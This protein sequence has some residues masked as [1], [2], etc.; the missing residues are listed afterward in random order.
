MPGVKEIIDSP[1]PVYL[2]NLAYWNFLLQSYEGGI[3]YTNATGSRH[4]GNILS[5]L[6][7]KVFAGGKEV[8]NNQV[9]GNLFRHIRE[10]NAD[11]ATRTKMSYYYNFCAPIIDIYTNHLFKQAIIDDWA[12]I[13]KAVEARQDDVDRMGSS[14]EEYRSDLF[15]LTQVYG[16]MFT[17]VDTPTAQ[18]TIL[19]LQDKIDQGQFPYFVNFPPQNVINWDLDRFGQLNWIM[20]IETE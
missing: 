5:E 19:N 20:I 15:N 13:A 16:H 4:D 18:G 12:T 17:V 3:N 11:F 8:S 7:V 1:H 2:N 14:I 6:F 9:E 10:T